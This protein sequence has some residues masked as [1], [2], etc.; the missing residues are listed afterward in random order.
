[1]SLSFLQ[2]LLPLFHTYQPALH[3]NMFVFLFPFQL[4]CEK[5]AGVSVDLK[6]L[7][8]LV[9]TKRLNSNLMDCIGK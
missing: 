2:L 8:E 9:D 1:M 3:S 5:K 4:G 7:F 6:K